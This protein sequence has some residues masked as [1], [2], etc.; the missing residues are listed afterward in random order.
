MC[1]NRDG[2][3]IGITEPRRVAAIS[4]SKR[5]ND[6]M[7]FDE[8]DSIV[9]YQIRYEGNWSSNT[10]IKFMTD[11]VLLKEIQYDFM[12]SKYSVIII[13]EAHERSVYT[14]ILIG[15][16]SRIVPLRSKKGNPLKLIVM[17]AT[18]RVEDFTE[19][20]RL[21]KDI[22]PQIK[23][24]S[25]QY[26]VS[27]HFNKHT[28][29]DYM[30]E[31]YRK[32][33]KIHRRLPEGGILIFVTGQQEV[34]TLCSKLKK[35]FPYDP[36]KMRQIEAATQSEDKKDQEGAKPEAKVNLDKYFNYN[37][38]R[39]IDVIDEFFAISYST[40][41][42][43]EELDMLD[44][45]DKNDGID[46]DGNLSSTDDEGDEEKPD[47]LKSVKT[48]Q[49]ESKI[50]G[51]EKPLYILPLYSLL[52]SDKQ[53][54]VFDQVPAGC[55]LCVVATNVAET[56][57]TIPNIKYVVDT[58]KVKMKFHDKLTGVSTFQI[59]WT[60][61]ASADQRSGRA[62]RTS[63][64]HC[65]RLY[66]SAVFNDEFPKFSEPEIKRKPVED[67]ILQM[68][69]LGIDRIANFPFPTPPDPVAVKAAESLLVQ[70]GALD[71]D[72]TRTKNLKDE[73]ITKITTLGKAMAS[74]PINPRYSKM[75]V[76]A[77]QQLDHQDK[78]DILSYIICL[79][80][81]L[82]VP[83]LFVDGDTTVCLNPEKSTSN[84][85]AQVVK[86][87]YAQV[88][89][90]WLGS[91]PGSHCMLLGDLMLLLVALG[92]IEYEQH[93]S[94]SN[95]CLKF[96]EQYGIRYKA[97]A[98]ARKLRKQ[99][100]NTVNLIFP[101]L[102]LTID[103]S[104]QPPSQQQAKLL[105]QIVLSGL[106][107]KIARKYDQPIED[108]STGK[109]IKHAYQ[110]IIL[111]DPIFVHPTS[112]LFKDLPEYVCYV[113]MV[114][115]SRMYMRFLCAIEPDWLPIYLSKQCKFE[116]PIINE[117]DA[118]YEQQKPRFDPTSGVVVCHRESV[119]GRVMWPIRPVEVEFPIGLDLYK[120]FARFL[121]QGEVI[122]S[123]K[124]YESVLLASPS[125]ML[126]SW[127]K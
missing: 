41:P 87:K 16:L 53:A 23:V 71:F 100:V 28:Y 3:I 77:S 25:R 95:G 36:E 48:D 105:R 86:V 64:G 67:L 106:V 120:W 119:F 61:K 70:L 78:L 22:P 21:F 46:E 14:D 82:S 18:L 30:S 45:E 108:K 104:M 62:G 47:P 20:R 102:N 5:V 112:A 123:L 27:V 12:L 125:T 55:R 72:A 49:N 4:M 79:I 54:R 59:C 60:S 57:L 17:S 10:K 97:I 11:G 24:D 37:K 121:L 117:S 33:C 32:V 69:D 42:L 111:E 1:V 85:E 110:S 8:K 66:S 114:E 31:A 74:F 103:P 75:L 52:S 56:S 2:Q 115:T 44:T 94:N 73:Q 51:D 43:D 93:K 9:S 63:P 7:N 109:K 127:A 80:S 126:K 81:G 99:L 19:N 98:E 58:G 124:K 76:L 65:Y 89:Q 38:I 34:H 83:E 40:L 50:Y 113:D 92:A 107:D 15:L 118:N 39:F 13:D 91:V 29:E 90:A 26:Q 88:R 84:H 6:E 35:T 101:H 116:K 68:K 96:C 122:D